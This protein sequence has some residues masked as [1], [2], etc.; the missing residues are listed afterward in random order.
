[1]IIVG[2]STND[3]V[4]SFQQSILH[5]PDTLDSWTDLGNVRQ[6]LDIMKAKQDVEFCWREAHVVFV[7]DFDK[8]NL[9]SLRSTV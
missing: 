6:G 3:I 1:M 9:R 4:H 2:M 5:L 8:R 7:G